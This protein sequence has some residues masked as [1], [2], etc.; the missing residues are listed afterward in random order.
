MRKQINQFRFYKQME[1]E[2][3]RPIKLNVRLGNVLLRD[4]FE[5]DVNNPH[6][7]PEDFANSLVAD[8]ALSP[9]FTV[10]IAFQ[11]REQIN[12]YQRA[13]QMERRGGYTHLNQY[14]QDKLRAIG[15]NDE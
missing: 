8:L 6:N 4:Q 7:S 1:G 14:K 11:I 10:L 12:E 5:W 13:A 2:L 3:V 15:L 9:E